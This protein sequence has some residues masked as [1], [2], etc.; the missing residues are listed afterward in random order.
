MRTDNRSDCLLLASNADDWRTT[1]STVQS[2]Q[3]EGA[4]PGGGAQPDQ[5]SEFQSRDVSVVMLNNHMNNFSLLL[6]LEYRGTHIPLPGGTNRL[7]CGGIGPACLRAHLFKV[8][9]HGQRD[10]ASR[11]LLAA[12]RPQA[13]VCCASSGRRYDS[14]HP[15]ALCPLTENGAALYFSD[16][17]WLP[18]L[19][20]PPHRAL[21]FTVEKNGSLPKIFSTGCVLFLSNVRTRTD[22]R[23]MP[24]GRGI[25]PSIKAR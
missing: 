17:P 9:H 4:I 18:G 8:G 14:T 25:F 1:A 19:A 15:E 16:C 21:A 22:R 5:V 20:L 3:I 24:D 10:G 13:A 23:G 11:E 12:I 7:G 6:L 2:R